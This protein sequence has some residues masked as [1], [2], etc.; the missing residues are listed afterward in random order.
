MPIFV[1]GLYSVMNLTIICAC[2]YFSVTLASTLTRCK[3]LFMN[4]LFYLSQA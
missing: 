3:M 4:F 1:A 2:F